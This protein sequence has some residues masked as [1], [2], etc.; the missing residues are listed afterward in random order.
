[1]IE[2]TGFKIGVIG[3]GFIGPIHIEAIRRIPGLEIVAIA[4][5]NDD[6]AK[7]YA[8]KHCIPKSYGRWRDLIKDPDVEVIHNCTPNHLHY[9]I[10]KSVIEAGKPLIAE[11]PLALNSRQSAELLELAFEKQV[12]NMVCFTYR[13]YPVIQQMKAMVAHGDIGKPWFV[14]GSYLQ[15][16]LFYQND[17]NWRVDPRYS[18][19]TRTIGDIGSHWC[20]I[21]QFVTMQ[22]IESVCGNFGKVWDTRLDESKSPTEKVDVKTEDFA[23]VLL[24]FSNGLIGNFSTSQIS[25]GRKNYI[26][27]EVTGSNC[28][29]SWN[30]EDAERLWV[31]Y[32]DKMNIHSLRDGLKFYPEAERF[33]HYSVG[34][35][36]GYS[37]GFKN[38]FIAFYDY[39]KTNPVWG[40]NE[41]DFPS[42]W[43]GHKSMLITDAIVES[44]EKNKWVDVD[45]SSLKIKKIE[46][47]V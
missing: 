17:Y 40:K 36:Q 23:T 34:H 26:H 6:K 24:K 25:A 18:G 8:K 27:L 14:W 16:W 37:S 5:R 42:F 1:M 10:N 38:L 31:G 9:E 44:V 19:S 2:M 3:A 41:P 43:E 33:C 39:L 20:E 32:R 22:R 35:P 21:A 12:P 29:V 7:K 28:S 4:G 13:M 11:K 15:D 47:V 30:H 45:Y 46:V